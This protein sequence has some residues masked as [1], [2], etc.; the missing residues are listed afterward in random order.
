MELY[1]WQEA[2]LNAWEKNHHRGIINVITGAG[3]TVTALEGM[4]R[5]SHDLKSRGKTLRTRIVVPTTALAVQWYKGVQ[6]YLAQKKTPGWSIGLYYGE[7]K[8]RKDS[9]ILILVVNSARIGL[10]RQIL[11]DMDAGHHVLL[12][13]DECHHYG[14]EENRKIF[15]FMQYARFRPLQYASLGL[16]ATPQ[17]PGYDTVLVPALGH[18]IYAYG[19]RQAVYDG[20]VTPYAV[21]T[22]QL[23]LTGDEEQLYGQYT[24]ALRNL[25]PRLLSAYPDLQH[26]PPALFLS[27]LQK[28]ARDLQDPS[29]MVQRYLNLIYLRRDLV[30]QARSR[31]DCAVHLISRLPR[32]DKVIFFCE[33]ITQAESIYR[34]LMVAFPSQVGL[35]HSQLPKDLR[36]R[37]LREFRE[38]TIRILAS[39]KALDE[40]VD[41]PDATVGVVVSSTTARR[42]RLQRLGRI[43]RRAEG[44]EMAT[45]Y[46]FHIPLAMEESLY[47]PEDGDV[48]PTVA[49]RYFHRE[50]AFDC[51]E[52]ADL[53][54]SLL[55]VCVRKGYRDEQLWEVRRQLEKGLVLSDWLLPRAT[56]EEKLRQEKDQDQRNYIICMLRM[57]GL[58]EKRNAGEALPRLE[59]NDDIFRL[60]GLWP[61]I[62]DE[63]DTDESLWITEE[64]L[65][66]GDTGAWDD[67]NAEETP[68]AAD[69]I[70][71]FHPETGTWS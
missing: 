59:T 56:L 18:E 46:F 62:R 41:V 16:S 45:L 49:L 35:Y 63:E 38:G 13:A 43:L 14:G 6:S 39:C 61:E 22:V 33:K 2:C 15:S 4:V 32:N 17:C 20:R 52:Y 28:I 57:A 64:D 1:A 36:A 66:I 10:S 51:D 9:D 8:D 44:K 25:H 68:E 7:Q 29:S 37:V 34:R 69:T 55:A 21:M 31:G 11:E 40:G 58:L 19:L 47:L 26:L 24:D 42:Q 71:M 65:E 54:L 53:A 48:H 30:C 12:I 3:K 67:E 5:L 70:L 60:R 23:N 50:A 27:A